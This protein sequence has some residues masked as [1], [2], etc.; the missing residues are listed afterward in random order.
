MPAAAAAAAAAAGGQAAAGGGPLLHP[1]E[2]DQ[3][4]DLSTRAG[5]AA[6]A[7]ASSALEETWDGS[8][9]SFPAF[10]T[11]LRLRA[12][13]A[14]WNAPAPHGILQVNGNNIL[15]HYEGI[16]AAQITNARQGR[17]D[18]RAIQ[19]AR[20]MY[21]CLKK[22]ITGDLKAQVFDQFG[23]ADLVSAKGQAI[24]HMNK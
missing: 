11:A 8:T 22:S 23:N 2:A 6:F 18:D 9:D 13:E 10:V 3:P 21:Q 24:I 4:F 5:A 17:F 7:T 14:K 20:A 16:T 19:N 1:F 15:T 12:S